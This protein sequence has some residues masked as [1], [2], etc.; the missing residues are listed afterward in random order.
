MVVKSR[1][2][3]WAGCIARNTGIIGAGE[4]LIGKRKRYR[5]FRTSVEKENNIKMKNW[6]LAVRLVWSAVRTW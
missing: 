2:M 6:K 4:M 1:R 5:F 3:G